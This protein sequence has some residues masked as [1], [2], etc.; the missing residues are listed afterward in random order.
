RVTRV[1]HEL[2]SLALK[3][4]ADLTRELLH[5]VERSRT[6]RKPRVVTEV[7]EILVQDR[8][9]ANPR[10]EDANRPP[11][12]PPIVSP[13]YAVHLVRRLILVLAVAVTA[14]VPSGRAAAAGFTQTDS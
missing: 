7:D 14:L 11:I 2:H 8:Q 12:H 3:V 13:G 9:A 4:G 5:L 1:D 6:I 10:V